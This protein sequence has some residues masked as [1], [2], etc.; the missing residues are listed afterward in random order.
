VTPLFASA[1][2]GFVVGMVF[3]LAFDFTRRWLCQRA[4]VRKEQARPECSGRALLFFRVSGAG[5]CAA[6]D[7]ERGGQVNI[8]QQRVNVSG[9]PE[10]F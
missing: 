3:L 9:Q 2:V 5:L 8:G 4:T 10:A 6:R 7:G 1:A